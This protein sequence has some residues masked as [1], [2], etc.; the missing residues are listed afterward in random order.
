MSVCQRSSQG[1]QAPQRSVRAA[2]GRD[3]LPRHLELT[4]TSA[5]GSFSFTEGSCGNCIP[6]FGFRAGC[7]FRLE[8]V[9]ESVDRNP[10]SEWDALSFCGSWRK[11]RPRSRARNGTHFPVEALNR[12]CIPVFCEKTGHAFRPPTSGARVHLGVYISGPPARPDI[13][14]AFAPLYRPFG[15][16][17]ARAGILKTIL[18]LCN[19][20]Q[21]RPA[22]FEGGRDGEDSR[23]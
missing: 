2:R 19:A 18:F 15:R 23:R 8:P 6:E 11:L 14:P 16:L 7:V 3:S 10:A 20:M 12:E 1:A 17:S 4:R 9:W 5:K 13:P 21:V 22:R